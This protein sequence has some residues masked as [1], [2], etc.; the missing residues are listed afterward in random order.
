MRGSSTPRRKGPKFGKRGLS[1]DGDK[2]S[3]GTA[4]KAWRPNS[5]QR[6]RAISNDKL[7]LRD[8]R[9]QMGMEDPLHQRDN[10]KLDDDGWEVLP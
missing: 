8:E 5:G 7:D 1:D 2:D 6:K 3:A 4:G 10:A 9:E